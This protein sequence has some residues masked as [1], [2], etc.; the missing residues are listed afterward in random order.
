MA[1]FNESEH[2]RDNKGMF[3]DK[4]CTYRQNMCYDKIIEDSETPT[5]QLSK[6]DYKII[7]S[8]AIAKFGKQKA[9]ACGYTAND[10]ILYKYLGDG[11]IEPIAKMPIVGNEDLINWYEARFK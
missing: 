3:T 10:F 6:Y 11:E 9:T 2:P 1:E 5:I 8:Q 4:S 7:S